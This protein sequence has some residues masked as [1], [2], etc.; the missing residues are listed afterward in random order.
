ME[1]QVKEHSFE[2]DP[3]RFVESFLQ[4]SREIVVRPR[5]FFRQLPGTPQVR[6][7]FIF[8]LVC[9][10]LAALFM[11]NLRQGDITLFALLLFSNVLSAFVGSFVLHVIVSKVFATSL[12]FGST[13]RIIAYASLMDLG[14]WIPVLGPIAYFYG[15]YLIYLG[16]QELHHLKPRQAGLAV[17]S[18]L[19]IVTVLLSCLILLAPDSIHEAMKILDPEQAGLQGP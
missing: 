7:P 1:Q 10:F 14:S 3:S 15:L 2:F 4:V 6:N 19:I 11:A 8:L 9:S 16:L 17:I 5:D 13:F 12:L 18:I